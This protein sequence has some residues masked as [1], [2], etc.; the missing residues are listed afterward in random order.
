MKTFFII[1]VIFSQGANVLLYFRNCITCYKPINSTKSH[2][3]YIESVRLR[4]SDC[5]WDECPIF[6]GS[7]WLKNRP[8]NGPSKKTHKT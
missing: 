3:S 1:L 7:I 4:A 8:K 2:R 6:N 5:L